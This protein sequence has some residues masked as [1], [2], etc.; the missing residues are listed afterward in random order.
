MTVAILAALLAFVVTRPWASNSVY[1]CFLE[2][3]QIREIV[4]PAEAPVEEVL[5]KQGDV[6]TKGSLCLRL[7]RA[8]LE[9]SLK[10]KEADRTLVKKEISII[11]NS[12]KDLSRLGPKYIELAQAEDAI[13]GIKEDL[14]RTEW[15]A[16]F[17]GAVTKPSRNVSPASSPARGR[18]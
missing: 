11:Q 15:R 10:Q 13:N 9:H 1:P 18:L 3:A 16:P 8:P 4:I 5:V 14:S 17:L 6:V 2:S 7:N 12:E